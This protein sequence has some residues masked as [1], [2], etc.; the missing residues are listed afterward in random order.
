MQ[1]DA[2]IDETLRLAR[3]LCLGVGAFFVTPAGT[4]FSNMS[5]VMRPDDAE[6]RVA[7]LARSC[8]S[9]PAAQGTSLFWSAESTEDS[10]SPQADRSLACVVAPVRGG[11]AWGGLLGVVDVWL[12]ELD[13]EQRAGL[14]ALAEGLVEGSTGGAPAEPAEEAPGGAEGFAT[15]PLVAE[16]LVGERPVAAPAGEA[17]EDAGLGEGEG[18][19]PSADEEP[20]TAEAIYEEAAYEPSGY[21]PSAYEPSG[22]ETADGEGAGPEGADDVAPAGEVARIEEEVTVVV[23]EEAPGE[24]FLGEILDN[25]PEGLV[26][27]RADGTIVLANQTFTTMTGMAMDAVLG[28]DVAAVLGAG[29]MPWD[30]TA[31]YGPGSVSQETDGGRQIWL[32]GLLGE[33]EPGRTVAVDDPNGRTL[34]LGVVGRRIESR[35]AGDCFVTL[36]REAVQPVEPPRREREVPPVGIQAILDHIQDGIVCCDAAGNVVVVNRA[37]RRLQGLGDDELQVGSPLP[38]DVRLQT[39]E[40]HPL[41][42]DEHPLVRS[43]LDDVPVSEELLLHNGE[44]VVHVSVS[45][46]P[47][48]ID[49]GDGA[50]AVLRDVTA[51]RER[52]ASLTHY[53]LHD[54]LTGVANR[55]LLMDTLRRMLD[56]LPRR[57]G[58]VSLIFLDLDRF[59]EINDEH[60]HEMG[61]EVLRAV[62]MRLERAVRGEDVV[63]RL[64]GDEF[65]IAHV[66]AD[67]LSDGDSVVARIRKVLSAPYRFG[68]LVLDVGASI[69]WVSTSS[70]AETPEA[71]ISQADRAMYEHKHSRRSASTE[72]PKT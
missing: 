59:K 5:D 58:F 1:P 64:G 19:A 71:L 43:M 14:L 31:S 45:S 60:G 51:E 36:V 55:Y 62:A 61:D 15:Q 11:T 63:A 22:Y 68:G 28:E 34:S 20:I 66:T 70:G 46:H 25:L 29:Q 69:G 13:E 49:G 44:D 57:G 42:F 47:L 21:E 12:P 50:I 26:V 37:A 27:T 16:P 2:S 40:G 33:P 17:E 52:Q 3:D 32:Q 9:H 65:V 41:S 56:G 10:G 30:E 39:P 53:A 67:R 6:S 72:G 48:R 4:V 38:S 18:G 8:L 24:P 54:P 35:F 23:R 7:S